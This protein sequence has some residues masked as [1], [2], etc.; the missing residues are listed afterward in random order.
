MKAS[1]AAG[2]AANGRI[3]GQEVLEH[4]VVGVAVIG[5]DEGLD[6]GQGPVAAHVVQEHPEDPAPLV[7]GHG[8]VAGPFAVDLDQRP[9]G[10]GLPALGVAGLDAACRSRSGR[11]GP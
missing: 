4:G 2:S 7:V 6:A 9:L 10:V 11:S 3:D 1:K 5:L 8:R